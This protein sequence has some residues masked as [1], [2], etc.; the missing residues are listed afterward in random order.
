MSGVALRF[1]RDGRP[2]DQT[3]IWAMLDAVPYRG[4]DGMSIRTWDHVG[5]GFARMDTTPEDANQRLP[6][7]SPRTGCVII[8]DARLD[9]RAELLAQLPDQ[10]DPTIGDADIILRAYDAW[11]PDCAVRFLGDFAFLIW[12]PRHQHVFAAR[13]TH[14][15]RWLYYRLDHNTF[16]AASEIHQLFQDPSVPMEPNEDTIRNM[17]VPINL[18]RNEKDQAATFYKDVWA[19]P[20]GHTLIVGRDGVRL[21]RYWE[22]QP[23]HEIRYKRQD[24]YA[25]HFLDLLSEVMRTRMHASRPVGAMLSGG[26]DSSTVVC[27]AMELYRTGRVEDRGFIAFNLAFDGLD[28]DERPLVEDIKRKYPNLDL[29]YVDPPRE[30]GWLD[31]DPRGFLASPTTGGSL[32]QT[33]YAAAPQAGVRVMLTGDIADACVRGSRLVFDS[34]LLHG[35]VNELRRHWRAYRR[36]SGES[37]ARSV[38]TAVGIPSLPL[39]LQKIINARILERDLK[40]E[41]GYMV[42]RWF[43]EEL[44]HELIDQHIRLSLQAEQAR[45]YA[46]PTRTMEYDQLYPPEFGLAPIG[47]PFEFRRPFADRR[48]HEFLFAIPPEE[49]FSPHPE[50]DDIYAA[51][52]MIVRRAM[53]GILPESIRTRTYQTHFGSFFLDEIVRAWPAYETAFGPDSV[54]ELAARGWVD[55]DRFWQRLEL[56]RDSG[57]YGQDFIYIIRLAAIETWLRTFNR[58]RRERV[59]IPGLH[60]GSTNTDHSVQPDV[61]HAR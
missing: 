11:G 34:L 49:K 43:G 14:G 19:L 23:G 25:E 40:R 22:L 18:F 7:V 42:P 51:S 13:D 60:S 61:S 38:V 39:P 3:D 57:N 17:L 55:Q 50:T 53:R 21:N 52:K 44:Q 54:S 46:S 12:D 6:L 5:L 2:V 33:L 26:L 4:P 56:L 35:K 28:C 15:Q 29:R 45:R 24:Q 31:P 1:H 16:A 47:T 10:A 32:L 8:A 41:T 48:L 9:N 58:P 30:L 36:V 20:A 59:T 37:V 27:T